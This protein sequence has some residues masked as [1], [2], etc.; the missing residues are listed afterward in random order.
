[1]SQD[2]LDFPHARFGHQGVTHT[3][4]QRI[5]ADFAFKVGF[6]LGDKDTKPQDAR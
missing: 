5:A 1:M 2:A 6:G 3:A 4:F